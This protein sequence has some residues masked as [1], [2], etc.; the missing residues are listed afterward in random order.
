M[1]ESSV[2]GFDA[3]LATSIQG[4]STMRTQETATAVSQTAMIL[5]HQRF[6]ALRLTCPPCLRT[7]DFGTQKPAACA[8]SPPPFDR[9]TD[10]VAI[11]G[12]IGQDKLG[13]SGQSRDLI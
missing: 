3:H 4:S 1:F 12:G 11:V 5:T 2:E 6:S 7:T 13:Y 9:L 8:A 10:R